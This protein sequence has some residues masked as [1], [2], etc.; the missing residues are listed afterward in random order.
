MRHT[1]AAVVPNCLDIGLSYLF[2][3]TLG[4]IATGLNGI[5]WIFF[6][7]HQSRNLLGQGRQDCPWIFLYSVFIH[8]HRGKCTQEI[9]CPYTVEYKEN[10]GRMP[11][12]KRCTL[13]TCVT[14]PRKSIL[15]MTR[16]FWP[17]RL[18][19]AAS[20]PTANSKAFAV[21]RNCGS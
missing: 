12:D 14:L 3:S 11:C 6:K 10:I 7:T 20:L 9:K 18:H 15:G 2:P 16:K 21:S 17:S 4:T 13:Y 8:P 19:C 1:E 5:L